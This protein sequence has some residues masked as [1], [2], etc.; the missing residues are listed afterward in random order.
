MP[1]EQD[2]VLGQDQSVYLS[3]SEVNYEI[4]HYT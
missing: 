4:L 2:L 3:S 1:R